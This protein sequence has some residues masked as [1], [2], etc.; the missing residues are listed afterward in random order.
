MNNTD[1]IKKKHFEELN[2]ICENN[3]VNFESMNKL[4]QSERLKKLQK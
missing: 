2:L 3:G 4:I 1:N